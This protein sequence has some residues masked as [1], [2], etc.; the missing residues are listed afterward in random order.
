L[1]KVKKYPGVVREV[2]GDEFLDSEKADTW[3][4][5]TLFEESQE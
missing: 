2:P 4:I 3:K 5:S 1:V